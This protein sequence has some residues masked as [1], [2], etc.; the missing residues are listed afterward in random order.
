MPDTTYVIVDLP[1]FLSLQHLF[2]RMNFSGQ[3][4]IK[5]HTAVPVKLERN[6]FNLLPVQLL[7]DAKLSGDSFISHFG[8]SK[9]TDFTQKLV[10]ANRFFDCCGLYLTGQYSR[11][12]DITAW[13]PHD[14]LYQAVCDQYHEVK[15][16]DFHIA[17][18]YELIASS[19]PR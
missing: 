1:E 4:A 8:L 10:I 19:R 7:P 2:L 14:L 13:R 11:S 17:G 15:A 3:R 9:T 12:D 18:N 6:A 16:L 5:A